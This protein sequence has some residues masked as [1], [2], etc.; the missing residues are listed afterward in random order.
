MNTEQTSENVLIEQGMWVLFIPEKK[1]EKKYSNVLLY[2]IQII[3]NRTIIKFLDNLVDGG[4][5]Y[6]VGLNIIS[7]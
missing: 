5:N 3:I 4:K 6:F 2:C 1:H 7:F